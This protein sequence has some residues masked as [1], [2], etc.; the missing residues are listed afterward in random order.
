MIT[1]SPQISDAK[2]EVK[3]M[4]AIMEIVGYSSDYEQITHRNPSSG[5]L[6]ALRGVVDAVGFAGMRRVDQ[7]RDQAPG[8]R[9]PGLRDLPRCQGPGRK[10]PADTG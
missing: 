2:I 5:S 10:G 9:W 7:Y 4:L 6:H 8:G 1:F 3:K